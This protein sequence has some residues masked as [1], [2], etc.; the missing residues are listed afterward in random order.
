MKGLKRL[1]LATAVTAA[2]TGVM[3]ELHMLDDADM[4]VVTGQAGL[5]IDVES[6]WEIGE[7]AYQDAGYLLIQGIRMGGNSL[8]NG[9]GTDGTML[10]NLRLEIDI[11]GDGTNG[12]NELAYGFS[13]M[14]DI[15]Q[16][17][18]DESN[19]D[20]RFADIAGGV[21]STRGNLAIDDKKIYNDG[22]LVIH[23]DFTD[24][25]AN[26]GGYAGYNAAGR[27][28]TDDY[29]VAEKVLEYA[30]DFRLE[31]DGIGLASSTYNVG[32]AG[33]DV[34]SN[35]VTGVHEGAAGTTTLISQLGIQG[36]LGPE[37]LYIQN[38]GNGFGLDGSGRSDGAGGTVAGTGN[39][40]SKIYW[41]SYFLITDLDVYIDIA[42]VQISDMKI[43]NSRGDLS[44]LDGTSAFGFANSVRE[45]YAVKD[46]VLNLNT[47]TNTT[48]ANTAGF[49]DGIAI[50]TRFK[51]DIDIGSIS[52]GDTGTSI[53]SIYITDMESTTNWTISAK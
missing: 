1:A 46:T 50:N 20:G 36:Y 53:G 13:N 44:G 22:D 31:I 8:G 47:L 42:G 16:M 33:L 12:D 29:D 26:E 41:G 35:F 7:F 25:W 21:D 40:D 5:T 30:V 6:Q 2:S 32:D 11:A 51:G 48:G 39:A 14:R 15:A 4:Q 17:Y 43:H 23:F 3:A 27:F 38:N 24:G 28:A 34:D 10:D 49:V 45:I 19:V 37:D 18:V 9:T 52:F